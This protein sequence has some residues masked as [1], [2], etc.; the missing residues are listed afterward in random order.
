MSTARPLGHVEN[1]ALAEYFLD[2][3]F[4][5]MFADQGAI[6]P[7]YQELLEALDKAAPVAREH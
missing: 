4:D 2:H 7:Q 3:A 5:E 6:R 1:P